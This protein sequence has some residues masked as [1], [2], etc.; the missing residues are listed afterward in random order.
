MHG[1]VLH[2]SLTRTC[3]IS[4]Q[5]PHEN[6]R[7]SPITLPPI[8]PSPNEPYN[9]SRTGS[10]TMGEPAG[11]RSFPKC[12][13][14]KWCRLWSLVQGESDN[15]NESPAIH[16]TPLII[17]DYFN[18]VPDHTQCPHRGA[19]LRRPFAFIFYSGARGEISIAESRAERT[20]YPSVWR[21]SRQHRLNL[22]HGFT[23]SWFR[24]SS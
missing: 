13:R 23:T 11:L 8:L 17:V 14:D 20:N 24:R 5:N 16:E 18:D 2:K 21:E 4:N 7:P 3:C 1:R 6:I 12:T 9:E 19:Q 10:A 22:F 15:N